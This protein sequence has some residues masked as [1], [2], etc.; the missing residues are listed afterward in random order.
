MFSPTE[1]FYKRL[2]CVLICMKVHFSLCHQNGG[3]DG[4]EKTRGCSCAPVLTCAGSWAAGHTLL[5]SPPAPPPSVGSTA[6][7]P[8]LASI[9]TQGNR[10]RGSG[11]QA[12]TALASAP[13]VPM[14]SHPILPL[15]I[16][17]VNNAD[18]EKKKINRNQVPWHMKMESEQVWFCQKMFE[19][20]K[21]R[22]T[23]YLLNAKKT[24]VT[25]KQNVMFS[26][27]D[28]WTKNI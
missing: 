3:D 5:C 26:R 7:V 24:K 11:Q 6:P 14:T 9:W 1:N 22:P 8:P 20:S 13:T 21:Q 17:T 19:M 27:Q 12:Q 28:C 16:P 4:G 2:N 10:V 15:Q 23:H 25:W 18:Q